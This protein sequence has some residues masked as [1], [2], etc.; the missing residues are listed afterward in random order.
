MKFGKH[1]HTSWLTL[2]LLIL[3][4]TAYVAAQTPQVKLPRPSQ[5][6]KVIQT[7]GVTDDDHL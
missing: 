3:G 5:K 6:A 7:I 1:I 4:S 2:A